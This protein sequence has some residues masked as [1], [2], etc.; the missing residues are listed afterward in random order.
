[1]VR[2]RKPLLEAHAWPHFSLMSLAQS[3]FLGAGLRLLYVNTSASNLLSVSQFFISWIVMRERLLGTVSPAAPADAPAPPPPPAPAAVAAP[4]LAAPEPPAA[5]PDTPGVP[6][7]RGT[8]FSL[9]NGVPSWTPAPAAPSGDINANG[10]SACC[11]SC[12]SFCL[13]DVTRTFF[14]LGP[15]PSAPSATPSSVSM[16]STST[17][18]GSARLRCRGVGLGAGAS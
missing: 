6:C 12:V 10:A 2:H 11:C 13:R 15:A 1:M 16:A 4:A 8:C 17:T 5:P 3:S 18:S 9:L 14:L 7:L